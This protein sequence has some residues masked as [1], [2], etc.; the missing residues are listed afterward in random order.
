[1]AKIIEPPTFISEKK[2]FDTYKKD[3]ERW[4]ELTTIEKKKQALMVLH[5][6]DGHPSGIKEKVD[7]QV[8][9]AKLKCEDGI[10]NLLSF[11]EN[12][13]KKDSL[14]DAFDKYIAFEKLRRSSAM[15]V[16]Q[17]IPEWN[18]AYAKAETVGCTLSDKVLAF[19]LLDAAN[20]TSIERN[21]VLTGVDYAKANLR[22]QMEKA[23]R[24]FVGRVTMAGGADRIEDSTYLTK[25]NIEDVL[26]ARGWTKEPPKKKRKPKE[27]RKKNW[28]GRDGK[29]AKCFKCVCDHEE[30]CECPCSYHIAKDCPTKN[31]DKGERKADLG[32]FMEANIPSFY[33]E[34]QEE[35]EEVIL[36][37]NEEVNDAGQTG[38]VSDV[39]LTVHQVTGDDGL[40]DSACPTTVAGVSWVKRY[41]AKLGEEQKDEIK[42]NLLNFSM[43]L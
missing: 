31:K 38:P 40:V 39:C 9:E 28:L 33:T 25:D 27:E 30:D 7:G 5:Y 42:V 24:K 19:K 13:Y 15:A 6:L 16:E 32:L 29:V 8:E 22:D 43:L 18:V 4:G 2:S 3:L 26:L 14:A 23:L 17:F 35:G 11:L 21:L 36:M 12:I 1:M 41:I 20:L 37:T 10:K 34:M